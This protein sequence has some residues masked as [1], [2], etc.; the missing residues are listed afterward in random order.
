MN[1]SIGAPGDAVPKYV[2]LC[3]RRSAK[4]TANAPET[5]PGAPRFCGSAF[6]EVALDGD[7]G[8]T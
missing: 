5:R 3:S 2:G 1:L 7:W 6:S 8:R 4:R